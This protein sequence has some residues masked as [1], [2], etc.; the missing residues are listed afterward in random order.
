VSRLPDIRRLLSKKQSAAG[1][2][3]IYSAAG[4]ATASRRERTRAASLRRKGKAM[5]VSA[6]ETPLAKRKCVPCEGGIEPLTIEQAEPMLSQLAQ[7]WHIEGN[8]IVREFK[9]RDFVAAMKFVKQV[10]EI[11]EQEGHHPD[12]HISWNRVRMELTTH[13]IGGLSDN[14]FIVA[15][16]MDELV[17]S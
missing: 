6:P 11:A 10:A 3:L 16:K 8:K 14:D 2:V 13:A 12:I 9:F 15:A 7:G 5:G 4:S 1:V 17:E